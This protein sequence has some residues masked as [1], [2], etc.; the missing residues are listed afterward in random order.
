M[1]GLMYKKTNK[2]PQRVDDKGNIKFLKPL[3]SQEADQI[4]KKRDPLERTLSLDEPSPVII[5]CLKIEATCAC[6]NVINTL[7]L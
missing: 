6:C 1:E 5:A 4:R 2:P 7:C 3:R